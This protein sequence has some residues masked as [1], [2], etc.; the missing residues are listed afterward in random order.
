MGNNDDFLGF[1]LFLAFGA[2]TLFVLVKLS[3][4][5]YEKGVKETT[6][7]CVE[8][9]QDCKIKYDYIKLQEKQK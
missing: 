2:V 3:D 9:P 5:G 8:K 7:F 4:I 1:I 6:I